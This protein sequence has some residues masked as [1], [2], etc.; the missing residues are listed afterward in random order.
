MTVGTGGR[1]YGGVVATLVAM[2]A[3]AALASG[4]GSSSSAED[5]S[6]D[7]TG[8][9]NGDLANTRNVGGPIKAS[10]VNELEVAWTSPIEAESAFGSYASSPILSKG[11]IYSQ[12]LASN[13]QAIEASSG[14]VLW[15]K[16]YEL[17]D[18]GPNGVVV[19]EGLVFGAT[20]TSA[21]ALDQETGKQVWS[22]PLIR[23]EQEGIDMAP[24]YHDG[25][26]YVSTVPVNVGEFYGAGG[27]GIVW[28]L[29]G[30]TGK[31][32][33]HFDTVPKDLWGKP[34]VNSGGGL[35]YTPAFDEHG[36]MYLGV[37]NPAPFPGTE[38]EPWGS[39]RPGP[40]LYSD[41]LVKLDAKTGKLEWYYQVTPHA[42]YD[43]DFQNPPVLV[44]AGGKELVLGAG[45][46][47]IVAALDAKTGKPVWEKTVGKH[48]GH[49]DDGLLAMRGETSKLKPP[50]LVY[51]GSLGGVI[52]PMATDGKT[53]FIP[54]VNAP[55]E[56]VTQT[57]RQ[58]P[59]P[60]GG[61]LVALDVKTG[62]LKWKHEF[63]NAAA[64]GFTTVAND[65]VF[66][67]TSDGNVQA[68]NTDT[69]RVTWQET[70]PSGTNAGVMVAGDMMIAPAGLAAAEGQTPQLV[71]F[72]LGG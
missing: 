14:D 34:D 55:L 8:Y 13:V 33:W 20:P 68:F 50:Y 56:I 37:G 27:V 28:A 60:I 18:H 53:V 39:S 16:K 26:V 32:L 15:T 29:D 5:M 25:I 54:V 17:P 48:N 64:F 44:D 35:W 9:P 58:E 31:K 43:W 67:T 4:C 69:G 11:V 51:P 10:T 23:N 42:L 41:A 2:L 63:P 47:G 1:G 72:R 7:G 19:Q 65:L 38:E 62:A 61:E 12:D 71:A 36:S 22:V 57:E 40:N 52:A 24:G 70:L 66:A 3:A 46:S 45:K 6:F 59:G 49:D 30:K 21:F